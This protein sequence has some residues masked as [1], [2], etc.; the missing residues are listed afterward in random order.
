MKLLNRTLTV[1]LFAIAVTLGLAWLART[2]WA[3]TVSV[4]GVGEDFEHPLEPVIRIAA[5]VLIMVS[6][7]K[8]ILRGWEY[9]WFGVLGKE[10]RRGRP[11]GSARSTGMAG[12]SQEDHGIQGGGGAGI[13]RG[14]S[15]AA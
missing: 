5:T 7:T 2:D 11:R 3:A 14:R 6:A 9:L 15:R 10:R 13:H 1:L 12:A 4:I 8:L